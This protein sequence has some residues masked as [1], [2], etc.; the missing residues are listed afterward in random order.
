MNSL[1]VHVSRETDGA[2]GDDMLATL[3]EHK[4]AGN[5]AYQQKD[6]DGAVAAYSKGVKLLPYLD[7]EDDDEG[8]TV[9][10]LSEDVKKQGA[11]VLCNR[12]AAFMGMGKKKAVAAL[13]D[14]QR[15]ADFD[16]SNWKERASPPPMPAALA[17]AR[18]HL[19][20]RVRRR[21]GGRGSRS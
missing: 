12:A 2:M 1:A 21:I 7:D 6:Y 3:L 4:A 5:A 16:P 11:V 9:A 20:P 15:A 13:A 14:A 8:A 10:S 18:R 19:P 17:H